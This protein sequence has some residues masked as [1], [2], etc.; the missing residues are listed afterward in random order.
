MWQGWWNYTGMGG[1][2]FAGLFFI[3]ILPSS[4]QDTHLNSNKYFVVVGKQNRFEV[5]VTE[6]A[7]SIL[8]RKFKILIQALDVLEKIERNLEMERLTS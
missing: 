6:M 4:S 2:R 7:A 1:L 5:E 8:V 3:F